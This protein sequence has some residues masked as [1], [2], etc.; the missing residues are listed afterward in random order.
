[1][2]ELAPDF[3]VGYVHLGSNSLGLDRLGEAEDAARQSLRAKN[4][5]PSVSP[6]AIRCRL[7]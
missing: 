2:I 7:S 4:R 6:P 3:G 5:D 1:M